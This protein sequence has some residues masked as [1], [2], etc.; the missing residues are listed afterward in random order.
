MRHEQY[1]IPEKCPENVFNHVTFAF[2]ILVIRVFTYE[3]SHMHL[4]AGNTE[5]LRNVMN[6]NF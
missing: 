5:H 2:L 3:S 6:D 1:Y 4:D